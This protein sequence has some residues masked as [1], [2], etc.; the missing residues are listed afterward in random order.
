VLHITVDHRVEKERVIVE[1]LRA[2]PS[3]AFARAMWGPADVIA[4]VEAPDPE[5]LR[6]VICDQV[7][8]LPGVASNTTLY[9][10]PD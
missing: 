5:T 10:Y 8:V 1:R 9:C 7:K 4:I 2:L 6:D 3:I